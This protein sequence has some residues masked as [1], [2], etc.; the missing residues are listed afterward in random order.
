MHISIHRFLRVD[1]MTYS[2]DARE[3]VQY[4]V[5][6]ERRQ[7]RLSHELIIKKTSDCSGISKR[8]IKRI[9]KEKRR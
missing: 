8:T 2:E 9:L 5:E 1:S 7:R 6:K 4:M 3:L